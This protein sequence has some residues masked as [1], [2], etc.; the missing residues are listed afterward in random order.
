MAYRHESH[1]R[2]DAATGRVHTVI[3]TTAHVHDVT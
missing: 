1:I 2:V 3:G